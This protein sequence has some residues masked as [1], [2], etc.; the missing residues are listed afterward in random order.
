MR[1]VNCI[2]GLKDIRRKKI[3]FANSQFVVSQTTAQVPVM[4]NT[5]IMI[6]DEM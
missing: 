2:L 3:I 4:A 1:E 6:R 5:E